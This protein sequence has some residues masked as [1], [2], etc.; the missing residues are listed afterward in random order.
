MC[1][2][3]LSS[4]GRGCNRGVVRCGEVWEN[5]VRYSEVWWNVVEFDVVEFDV[6]EGGLADVVSYGGRIGCGVEM[7]CDGGR[8]SEIW[9]E[10]Q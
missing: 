9:W 3:L 4:D 2:R 10:I 5:V 8:K 1:T 6:V 7:G